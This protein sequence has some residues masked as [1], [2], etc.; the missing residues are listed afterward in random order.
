MPI[1]YNSL[2]LRVVLPP[3]GTL[4][5]Q[6]TLLGKY[7]P[8]VPRYAMKYI[9]KLVFVAVRR[10]PGEKVDNF[11][12]PHDQLKRFWPAV[13]T[14]FSS[15]ETIRLHFNDERCLPE[16]TKFDYESF[17]GLVKINKLRRVVIE[18]HVHDI[19]LSHAW[20]IETLGGMLSAYLRAEAKLVQ[21]SIDVSLDLT[22]IHQ[23]EDSTPWNFEI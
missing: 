23:T 8:L 5:Y 21:K 1:M 10:E 15:L 4:I 19:F 18:M 6:R 12:K 14:Q 22:W 13:W 9:K 20:H 16:V 7:I 3:P 2:E 17:K 11:C